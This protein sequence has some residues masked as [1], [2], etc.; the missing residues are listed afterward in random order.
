MQ[1]ALSVTTPGVVIYYWIVCY[2]Q[3]RYVSR[4]QQI[5]SDSGLSVVPHVILSRAAFDTY[6]II[7]HHLVHRR[8]MLEI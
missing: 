5:A 6:S 2:P 4:I 1:Q 3:M 8:C 7:R